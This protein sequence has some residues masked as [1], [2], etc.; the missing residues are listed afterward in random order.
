M[1]KSF[2]LKQTLVLLSLFPVLALASCLGP[3]KRTK[4]YYHSNVQLPDWVWK[5]DG[6]TYTESPEDLFPNPQD[7]LAEDEI[8]HYEENERIVLTS[9][10]AAMK[11]IFFYSGCVD[12]TKVLKIV[13]TNIV[14]VKEDEWEAQCE[15][16][17]PDWIL[18]RIHQ[19]GNRENY[20]YYENKLKAQV[21][22]AIELV[23]TKPQE[24]ERLF[25]L[26]V[27]EE[28]AYPVARIYLA[29]LALQKGKCSEAVRNYRIV[30]RLIPKPDWAA[31]VDGI[32][33]SRKCI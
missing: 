2:P 21:F 25:K 18:F 16:G 30:L 17:K 13:D 9:T 3:A 11:D 26:V 6:T 8:I 19:M 27:Q 14:S 24:A 7:S 10:P 32:L 22:E 12:G 4:V 15:S 31:Q 20:E 1:P 33:R 29:K 5:S 23:K 28:P